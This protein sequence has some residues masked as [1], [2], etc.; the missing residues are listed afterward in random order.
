MK[1]LIKDNYD[2][3]MQNAADFEAVGNLEREI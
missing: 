1:A 3:K 2:L